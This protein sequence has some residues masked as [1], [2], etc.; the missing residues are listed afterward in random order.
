MFAPRVRSQSGGGA[1]VK[2][3]TLTVA[4]GSSI[5]N[6]TASVSSPAFAL[7]SRLVVGS[8]SYPSPLHRCES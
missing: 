8:P 6:N 1:K 4:N 2:Y 7:T 3:S 5:D